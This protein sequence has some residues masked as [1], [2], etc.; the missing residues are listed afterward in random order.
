[1]GSVRG[2]QDGATCHV[3]RLIVAPDCRRR[4]F[5]TA[6]LSGIE[7]MFP[8]AERFEL[9]TG[10]KSASNIRLY[11]RQGYRA[12]R[13]RPVNDKVTLVYLEKTIDDR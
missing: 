6:L 8:A 12:F 4:G 2:F 5:G 9:F 1:M 13:Q 7:T 11:E 10:H 3:Q